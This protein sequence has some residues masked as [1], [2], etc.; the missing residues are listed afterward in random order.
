MNT[1]AVELDIY[2]G[3]AWYP[4]A[5]RSRVVQADGPLS[6]MRRAEDLENVV[7]DDNEYAAARKAVA[8]HHPVP[9]VLPAAA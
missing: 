6:A 8:V 4:H 1:Y 2:R 5:R 3:Q 9:A 7:V